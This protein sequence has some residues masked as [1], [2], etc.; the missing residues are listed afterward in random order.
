MSDDNIHTTAK[1]LTRAAL[2]AQGSQCIVTG[3]DYQRYF[4]GS[5][6]IEPPPQW[7]GEER[8]VGVPDRR[9]ST[10]DRRWDS[11]RGRRYRLRDRRAVK[12]SAKSQAQKSK[13][14]KK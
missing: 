5:G 8:R 11:A 7:S 12:Q 1:A 14:T 6:A 10:H 9:V 4:N 2:E 3:R 13:S